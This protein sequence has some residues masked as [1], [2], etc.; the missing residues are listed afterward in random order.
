MQTQIIGKR[1]AQE[2][3]T[4]IEQHPTERVALQDDDG[5][6]WDAASPEIQNYNPEQVP[7]DDFQREMT[8]VRIVG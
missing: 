7:A 8:L 3:W 6:L 2:I 5:E 1:T 4:Y